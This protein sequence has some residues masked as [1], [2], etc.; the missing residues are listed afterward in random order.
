VK[1]VAVTTFSAGLLSFASLAHAQT[2]NSQT[3]GRDYEALAYLPKD[4]LVALTY[5]REVSTSDKSSLSQSQGIFRA[6]YILK[7]GD[8]SIVPFDVLLP[9]VDVSVYIPA[10]PMA[11]VPGLSGTLHTSGLADATYLPTI[12]YTITENET[13]HTVIAATGYITAPTGSYDATRIVNIGDNRWRIQPQ[14]AVSQR[15][16]KAMTVDLVG[17]AAFYTKN[18]D[19]SAVPG[20][21]MSQ[22]QTFGFEAHAT[23]DLS[24]D[25]YI[26]LSYYLQAIGAKDVDTPGMPVAAGPSQTLQT[27][28]FTYGIGIEKATHLLL[29][30]NQDI[31][32]SGGVSISRF[33]GAR[34]SHA[35]F[36]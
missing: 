3:D 35:V 31:E 12:G 22:D 27:I 19:F 6:S 15:F 34:L 1:W 29:Q 23:A 24:K 28:R 21:T 2:A 26:G 18:S 4:T 8:L 9:V 11:P 13:S 17:S 20:Q 10:I 36:F 7:F 14:V 32:E 33:I 5:F 16:L 25:M 30:Y